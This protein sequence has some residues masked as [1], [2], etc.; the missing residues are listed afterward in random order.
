MGS[1]GRVGVAE[2]QKAV[3]QELGRCWEAGPA[4]WGTGQ[5]RK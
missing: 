2:T 4:V 5:Q 1:V 3:L